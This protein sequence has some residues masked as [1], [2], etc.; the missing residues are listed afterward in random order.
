MLLTE[1][2]KRR[3]TLTRPV[4]SVPTAGGQYVI[5]TRR[6]VKERSRMYILVDIKNVVINVFFSRY[7]LSNFHVVMGVN[8]VELNRML[9]FFHYVEPVDLSQQLVLSI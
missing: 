6:V 3:Y 1:E 9:Y 2:P 8:G 4:S 7:Y 5:R